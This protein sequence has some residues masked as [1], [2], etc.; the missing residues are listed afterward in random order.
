[1]TR[2][3][4]AL[5]ENLGELSGLEDLPQDPAPG[6]RGP[7]RP[8]GSTTTRKAVGNKARIPARTSTGKIMSKSEMAAKVKAELLMGSTALLALWDIKDP[9]C[10]LLMWE[11]V[12]PPG[13]QQSRLEAIV[14]HVVSI[15]SRNLSVLEFMA[16]SGLMIE[17]SMLAGL[18]AP[19]G[20][21][22]W[23]A[24]GPG[25]LGHSVDAEQVSRDYAAQFPAY[26]V[27]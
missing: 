14:D 20:K 17:I 24:H 12:G 6:K 7:G 2:S 25:S 8:R 21:Q 5:V 3:A 13:S 26:A 19:I 9:E 16:K 11:M 22:V 23:K 10:A 27:A 1:M 4:P 18:L 15:I